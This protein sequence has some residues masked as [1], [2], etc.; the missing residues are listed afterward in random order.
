MLTRNRTACM[1]VKHPSRWWVWVG[2]GGCWW[3]QV[4]VGGCECVLVD[5]SGFEC[6]LIGG[7]W[8]MLVGVAWRGEAWVRIG[9]RRVG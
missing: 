9:G 2:V 4:G 6:V 5:A 8:S 3:V 7:C 1:A